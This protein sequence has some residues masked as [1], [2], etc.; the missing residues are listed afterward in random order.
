MAT[1]APD[2]IRPETPMSQDVCAVLG[3]GPGNGA[4][5]GKRFAD[6]GCAVALCARERAHVAALAA[7]IPGARPY[8]LDVRDV[9]AHAQVLGTIAS[10]LGPV[11]TLV[12]NAG[13]GVFADF[14]AATVE[15]LEEAWQVNARGLFAAAKAVVPDMRAAGGG[16]IVVIGATA[17]RRGGASFVP[18]AQAKAAQR[19]LAESLARHLGPQGIHVSYVV[20]DGVIATPRAR[21]RLPDQPDAFF[22]D[23]AAIADAVYFL[24]R[25]PR[26]AWTFELDLRPHAERW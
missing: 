23:P 5:I 7:A 4:A 1:Y 6:A 13:G 11:R 22:L 10:D 25:Q 18:F 26:R 16:A 21:A 12:Y 8:V 2:S 19:V 24:A 15:Q 3:A 17:A 14:D 20:V 9:P